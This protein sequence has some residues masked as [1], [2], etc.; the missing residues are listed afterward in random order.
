[1]GNSPGSAHAVTP[2]EGVFRP[3]LPV[4][5]SC[6]AGYVDTA[7]FLALQGLFTAHVTGN[8]VTLGA[9]LIHGTTG[10]IGKLLALP[11]FCI[12]VAATRLASSALTARGQ[13]PVE[14]LLAVKLGL[15]IVACLL[16][17]TLGPFN[18][19]DSWPALATGMTL[20]AAMAIQNTVHRIHLSA[21]P[22]STLMTGSTTQIMIDLADL[23]RGET[24]NRDGM[25]KRLKAMSISVAAFA[26]GCAA[27]ALLYAGVNV[28]CFVVPPGLAAIGIYLARNTPKSSR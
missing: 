4:L 7:A 14:S 21:A 8:F 10:A 9:T 11:V 22:P 15:L 23:L 27:G 28:W 17:V 26:V 20:V 1:M 5:L 13:R 2:P 12:V 19:G 3:L 6:T 25:V 24:A 18:N 16:A